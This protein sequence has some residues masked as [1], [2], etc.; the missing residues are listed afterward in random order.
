[1]GAAAAPDVPPGP[2]PAVKRLSR[3]GLVWRC[4]ALALG[5]GLAVHG[6]AVGDDDQW[7]FA[8]MAQFAFRTD[9]DGDIKSTFVEARTTD[10]EL[11]RVPLNA[12]GT[13]IARAEIEGQLPRIVADPA[14]LQDV[15]VAWRRLHPGEPQYTHLWLKQTVYPLRG[16]AAQPSHVDTLA[17]WAV[18]ADGR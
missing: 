6:T 18:T 13:G 2:A 1:V 12:N 5:V 16:G 9:P 8:P 15:A 17:E 11:V 14:L 7:P 10:G 3:V 4:A